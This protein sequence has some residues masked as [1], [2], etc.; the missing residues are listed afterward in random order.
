MDIEPDFKSKCWKD[1]EYKIVNYEDHR[2][3]KD[4]VQNL[5]F[6][7]QNNLH[8][9]YSIIQMLG[10]KRG[11]VRKRLSISR[12]NNP[13]NLRI[14]NASI[15]KTGIRGLPRMTLN[16]NDNHYQ[17]DVELN[18]KEFQFNRIFNHNFAY[19]GRFYASFQNLRREERAT[20]KIDNEP[21]VELDYKSL[22]PTMLYHQRNL[23]PP[24]DMYG[25]LSDI[26]RDSYK[27]VVLV[28][29]N[30]DSRNSAVWSLNK[31]ILDGDIFLSGIKTNHIV[32][33]IAEHHEPIKKYFF[34]G[35]G[36]NLM[37]RD[38]RIA[39]EIMLHFA[40]LDKPCLSVHDSFIVKEQDE[41]ELR[42]VMNDIYRKH[43]KHDIK[44][45]KK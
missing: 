22:H 26:P 44:I 14:G 13:Q 21:T 41:D 17:Q 40:K 33:K 30:A 3:L 12:E 15:A 45:E 32:D 10:A 31:K 36:R 23:T 11:I 42:T 1:K 28:V 5:V 9:S 29:L 18:K 19:N 34:T 43:F 6:I 2:I 35:R 8:H 4:W 20:L 25:E 38:S 37:N 27:I 16:N 39:N 7:N 24:D